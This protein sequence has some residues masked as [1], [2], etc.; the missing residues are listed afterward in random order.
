MSKGS[1]TGGASS[2]ASTNGL[3][4]GSRKAKV[5][6]ATGKLLSSKTIQKLIGANGGIAK[7][8][9]TKGG[10]QKAGEKYKNLS[11]SD[12]NKVS[13]SIRTVHVTVK[14]TKR[15]MVG[16]TPLTYSAT[17]GHEEITAAK[18]AGATTIRATVTQVGLRGKKKTSSMIINL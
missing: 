18:K 11:K 14:H 8:V 1:G 9:G 16:G 10:S 6:T 15:T 12:V 3:T 17:A 13:N 4:G 2:S 7:L 5:E